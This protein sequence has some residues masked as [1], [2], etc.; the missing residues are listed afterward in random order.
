MTLSCE[1]R[2][3]LLVKRDSVCYEGV[4]SQSTAPNTTTHM[5]CNEYD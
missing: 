3:K 2:L 5:E 4:V 1:N